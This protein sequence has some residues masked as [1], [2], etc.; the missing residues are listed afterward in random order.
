MAEVLE[1]LDS[2][3]HRHL[4]LRPS[5][6]QLSNFVQ[7]I[8]AEF[9]AAAAICPI[10][11]AKSPQTGQFYA[12]A[13]FGF[14]PGENLLADSETGIAPFRPLD[15]QREAFFISGENIA[16]DRACPR[17]SEITGEPLFD[18][19]G[20]PTPP[21]RQIQRILG[22]LKAG[23]DDWDR[24]IALMLKHSLVEP[25]DISLRFDD[26]ETLDLAGLYSISIDRLHALNDHAVLELFRSGDL[27]LAFSVAASLRQVTILAD[28]RNRQLAKAA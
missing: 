23:L 14:K 22:Q 28:R 21:T 6:T 25:V 9:A 4:R 10:L 8:P 20:E 7:I 5:P 13:M 15:Q 11:F 2:K 26:G 3:A 18:E 16:I 19:D 1:I 24:F 17:I 12:G 27:H